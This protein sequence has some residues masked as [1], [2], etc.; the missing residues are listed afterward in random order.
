MRGCFFY[1]STVWSRM[2]R[3]RSGA[4]DV[5]VRAL[6]NTGRAEMPWDEEGLMRN[7]K[8]LD[9]RISVGAVP[10]DQDMVQLKE[11]GYKTLVDVRE[12]AERFGG[13]V[14]RRAQ[15]LGLRYVSIPIQRADVQLED[16]IRFYHLVYE[17]GSAPLY[18]FSR[19]GRKPLAFLLLFQ[20]VAEDRPL[21]WLFHQANRIGIDLW[22]DMTLQDFLIGFF[23]A[24]C[25]GEVVETIRDLRPDLLGVRPETVGSKD[26]GVSF[27]QGGSGG[28]GAEDGAA[29]PSQGSP[30]LRASPAERFAVLPQRGATIWLTGLP[31][32]GKTTTALAVERHLLGLGFACAVVDSHTLRSG[33]C[34]D[35]GY[36]PGDRSENIRR[37]GEAAKLLADAGLLVITSLISPYSEGRDCVATLHREAGLGF[38]EILVDAPLEVCEARDTRTLYARAFQGDLSGFTGVNGPYEP[39][40]HPALVVDTTAV[41]PREAASQ[42]VLLLEQQGALRRPAVATAAQ[43]GS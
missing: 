13:D 1:A 36:S 10:D 4:L 7:A 21:V 19:Q 28:S 9:S 30:K 25:I 23:N 11:L 38:F 5:M 41:S 16:V 15:E 22:G 8:R 3:E 32:A 39:P 42:I 43:V 27:S 29:S 35:L 37:A 24:G 40:S 14:E 18:L 20:A 34:S 33:L 6:A 2:V 31:C 12:E 17:K 26:G